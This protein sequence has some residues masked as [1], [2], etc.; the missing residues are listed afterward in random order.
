MT[1]TV[2][3]T[4]IF[5]GKVAIIVAVNSSPSTIS[6]VATNPAIVTLLIVILS[7]LFVVTVGIP[8]NIVLSLGV[9]VNE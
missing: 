1:D 6:Y 9:Y 3:V 8:S 2:R 5:S 4:I 7:V